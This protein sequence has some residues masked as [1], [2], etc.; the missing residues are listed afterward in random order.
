MD[1]STATRVAQSALATVSAES[2]VVSRN[3]AGANN[4]GTFTQKIANVVT[5]QDGGAEVISV[6]NA[7]N[8]ALFN[9]VLGATSGSAAFR[10]ATNSPNT[11]SI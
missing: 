4:S 8:Q 7:Q 3:I 10:R 9:S 6:A 2:N 1:L 11:C 5:I